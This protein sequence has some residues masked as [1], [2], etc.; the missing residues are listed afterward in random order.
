MPL[1]LR[2]LSSSLLVAFAVTHAHKLE[3]HQ[4]TK[5]ESNA[6][7]RAMV[8]KYNEVECSEEYSCAIE[9]DLL[10]GTITNVDEEILCQQLCQFRDDCGFYTWFDSNATVFPNIC[11]HFK[12]CSKDPEPCAGCHSAPPDCPSRSTVHPP[13]PEDCKALSENPPSHG[14][15]DCY[16]NS[17]GKD[18]CHLFCD[19]GFV[20]PGPSV[21]SC[22]TMKRDW[23]CEPSVVLVAGG[24]QALQQVEVYSSSTNS[25]R[26]SLPSLPGLYSDHS[27]D[28]VDGRVLL[29]GG[30]SSSKECL[31]LLPDLSWAPHSNLT[32]DRAHQTSA[33][34]RNSLLLLGGEDSSTEEWTSRTGWVASESLPEAASIDG[35]A[36]RLS[37][38]EILLTGGHLCP[39]CSFILDQETGEWKRVGDLHEAR[40]SH[41]CASYINPEDGKVRVLVAGGWSGHNIR[42]A[43]VYNP[44]AER[45]RVVGDL[46][47]PRRGLTLTTADGG[48]VM[49]LGGRFSTAIADVDIFDPEMETWTAKPSLLRSRAYHAATGV[50]ASMVGCS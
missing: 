12:T 8:I 46:S 43:E 25:C 44:E 11:F 4:E 42:T 29:C 31:T 21:V 40:S 26:F 47:S 50:P 1:V 19:P 34:R 49:A 36:A 5:D 32:Q 7:K 17:D 35:C 39:T 2:A 38:S 27:L 37:A 6:L 10:I 18:E 24:D 22:D 3:K 20:T 23:R 9:G 28:Y 30:S 45:W 33:V 16:K 13:S 48:R 15:W 14:A 41:G